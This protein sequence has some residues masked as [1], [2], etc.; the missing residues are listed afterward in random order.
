MELK[1]FNRGKKEFPFFTGL[2]FR[3]EKTFFAL[4]PTGKC[5]MMYYEEI[6]Y[7]L[8]KN[9]HI[10]L[11]V[12]EPWREFSIEEYGIYIKYH[13]SK[14]LGFDVWSEEEDVDLFYRIKKRYKDD[15]FYKKYTGGN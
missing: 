11:V 2:Y 4:Y 9:L 6:E 8:H 3:D 5:S 1:K 7:P 13:T 12:T 14:Y 10:D 15:E